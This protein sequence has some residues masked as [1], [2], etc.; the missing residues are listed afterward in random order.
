MLC[1]HIHTPKYI[2]RRRVHVLSNVRHGYLLLTTVSYNY[3]GLREW[4]LSAVA[5][6]LV[7]NPKNVLY[8]ALAHRSPGWVKPSGRFRLGKHDLKAWSTF[9]KSDNPW[10]WTQASFWQHFAR[11]ERGRFPEWMS[12][13]I[14]EFK[15]SFE[16][17][18]VQ[19][20]VQYL[21]ISLTIL[22]MRFYL[23]LLLSSFL[24]AYHPLFLSLSHIQKCSIF[25]FPCINLFRFYISL[26][27][28]FHLSQVTHFSFSFVLS[29]LVCVI[30]RP[31]SSLCHT[32]VNVIKRLFWR[33][34]WL[35]PNLKF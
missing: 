7:S 15:L 30:A 1:I 12:S 6:D 13:V 20:C 14:H 5:F 22:P 27:L 11:I 19:A 10:I 21:H 35:F 3:Q 29:I 8:L 31:L 4:D 23:S 32:V 34:S 9:C 26:S 17:L 28:S 33:K 18:I 24:L 25:L 2:H 16:I